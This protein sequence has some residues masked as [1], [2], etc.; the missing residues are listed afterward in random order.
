[1]PR[2]WTSQHKRKCEANSFYR[3]FSGPEECWLTFCGVLRGFSML[4]PENPLTLGLEHKAR[5]VKSMGQGDLLCQVAQLLQTC[6][7]VQQGGGQEV[8][9]AVL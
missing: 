4:R 9:P 6:K 1:M 7:G 3:T 8:G 2:H 5:Q